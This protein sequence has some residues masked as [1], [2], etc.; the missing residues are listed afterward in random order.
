[1]SFLKGGVLI[2]LDN[3][4]TTLVECFVRL[5]GPA[6]NKRRM[7]G[8]TTPTVFFGF[9]VPFF[10]VNPDIFEGEHILV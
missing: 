2:E 7:F 1:M 4:N 8:Q 6:I 3:L 10:E 5:L 9:W